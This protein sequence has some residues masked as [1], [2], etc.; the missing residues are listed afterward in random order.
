SLKNIFTHNLI[1][2]SPLRLVHKWII[3]SVIMHLA[4]KYIN[5]LT[6]AELFM[7]QS[8]DSVVNKNICHFCLSGVY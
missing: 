6:L 5:T 4:Y 1:H 3:C 2:L 7:Q 8:N